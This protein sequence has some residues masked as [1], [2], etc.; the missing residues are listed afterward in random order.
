MNRIVKRHLRHVR[1]RLTE[2]QEMTMGAYPITANTSKKELRIE[3][4]PKPLQPKPIIPPLPSVRIRAPL[5]TTK[6]IVMALIFVG[7]GVGTLGYAYIKVFGERDKQRLSKT[8]SQIGRNALSDEGIL[9][10]AYQL[11]HGFSLA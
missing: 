3:T 8:A 11:M 6:S 7:G 9:V 2:E 5:V 1:S 10:Y 4:I